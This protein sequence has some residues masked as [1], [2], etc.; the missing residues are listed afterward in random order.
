MINLN[1]RFN[2]NNMLRH[3]IMNSIRI[4]KNRSGSL[5]RL[6]RGLDKTSNIIIRRRGTRLSLRSRV[7]GMAIQRRLVTIKVIARR[8]FSGI[9]SRRRAWKRSTRTLIEAKRR[10][11]R[12]SW[13]WWRRAITKLRRVWTITMC[14]FWIMMQWTRTWRLCDIIINLL[15]FTSELNEVYIRV[16]NIILK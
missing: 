2:V 6:R 12:G 1:R 3:D 9:I 10:G 16:F 8:S 5:R 15:S 11:T 14:V 7:R 13:I 4:S